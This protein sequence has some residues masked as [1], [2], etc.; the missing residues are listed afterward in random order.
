M[1]S[2]TGSHTK[3]ITGSPPSQGIN[4]SKEGSGLGHQTPFQGFT[5]RYPDGFA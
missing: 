2:Y 1:L 4:E 3:L 5:R